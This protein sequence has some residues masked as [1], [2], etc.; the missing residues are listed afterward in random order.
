MECPRRDK[1]AR[2]AVLLAKRRVSSVEDRKRSA[3][4]RPLPFSSLPRNL[5]VARETRKTQ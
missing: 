3:S 2:R 4:I 5:L 1:I